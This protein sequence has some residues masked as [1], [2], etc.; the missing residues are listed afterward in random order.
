MA[1]TPGNLYTVCEAK[2]RVLFTRWMQRLNGLDAHDVQ[3]ATVELNYD[4]RSRVVVSPG[5]DPEALANENLEL[6]NWTEVFVRSKGFARVSYT[7]FFDPTQGSIVCANN[8]KSEDKNNPA[9]RLEW[10][11]VMFQVYQKVAMNLLQPM[12]ELRTIWRHWIVNNSTRHIL[13]EALWFGTSNP[14][15]DLDSFVQ[16]QPGA[17][18]FFAILGCQNGSGVVRM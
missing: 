6:G 5:V 2:G 10:S 3:T 18:G 17:S 12:T 11:E 15:R 1:T 9:D 14:L 16:Y 8:D 13:S 4:L 7:N